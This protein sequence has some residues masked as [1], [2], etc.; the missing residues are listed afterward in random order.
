[1]IGVGV[2]G[3]GIWEGGFT[4]SS[5]ARFF[6]PSPVIRIISMKETMQMNQ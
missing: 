5:Y 2:L 3:N 1:M 6:V 4:V